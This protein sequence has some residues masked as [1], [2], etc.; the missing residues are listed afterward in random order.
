MK[1][2][3]WFKRNRKAAVIQTTAPAAK[4]LNSAL[5]YRRE[6]A[7][8]NCQQHTAQYRHGYTAEGTLWK[9]HECLCQGWQCGECGA[10]NEAQAVC[11]R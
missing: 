4:G 3:D 1:F 6:A 11:C 10:L 2:S 8:Q 7:C 9:G 5:P